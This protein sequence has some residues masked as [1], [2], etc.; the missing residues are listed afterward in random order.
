ML[1]R[2][3]LESRDSHIGPDV[4]LSQNPA[5]TL[6][7]FGET[8]T[9]AGVSVHEA[10]AEGL[11]T[12]YACVRVLA[13]SI[14]QVPFKLFRR[15]A[16]GGR[17]PD[18][19]HPLYTL[20]HDLPNPEMTS[21]DVRSTLARWLFLWGNA[22]AEVDRRPDGS[23]RA[24]WPLRA[25]AMRIDRDATNRLRYRYQLAD[26]TERIWRFDANRPPLWHW[27]INTLDGIVGRSPIR[28]QRESLGLARAARD[29]G[30]GYFGSGGRPSGAL[31]VPTPNLTEVQAQD[32]KRRWMASRQA[33]E[34]VVLGQGATW[35]SVTTPPEDAQFIE[36]QRFSTESIC[37]IFGVPP[38]MVGATEKSTSW[39][40]GIE[41]QKI[42]FVTFTLAPHFEQVQQAT[43]RD[44]LTV[45]TFETHDALF[46]LNALLR[47]DMSRRFS[48]Y[49][50]GH[51][52][53]L[54]T[55][56]IRDLEDLNPLPGGDEMGTP[57]GTAVSRE[58]SATAAP[59]G[60][61]A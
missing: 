42:G 19:K 10:N 21:F 7:L 14:A 50:T 1:I 43:K 15:T 55:N 27:R 4:T 61:E 11:D 46:V 58:P 18:E 6:L 30:A 24:L 36:T 39:G 28:L 41:E 34:P 20:L 3:L 8:P 33:H 13:D 29:Y 2:R 32:L 22:Y 60:D 12:V 51:N 47:G 53:W 49:L 56:E 16:G 35:T 23:I 54:T 44:L 52:R 25:D 38:F 5:D 59:A 37:R 17:V 48:A 40:T 45:K 57:A 26:G 31:T 9:A